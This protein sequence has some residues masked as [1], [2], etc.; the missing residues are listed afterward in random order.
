[1][2]LNHWHPDT[3]KGPAFLPVLNEG[4][5]SHSKFK[6][7]EYITSQKKKNKKPTPN[8]LYTVLPDVERAMYMALSN[9]RE[10]YPVSHLFQI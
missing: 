3:L 5:I 6:Q 7:K 4:G 9:S 1:M 10:S 2:T 8:L